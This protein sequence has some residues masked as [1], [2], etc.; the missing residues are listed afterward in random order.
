MILDK[1][2]HQCNNN[3]SSLNQTFSMFSGNVK[4]KEI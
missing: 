1:T 4:K 3:S 2:F